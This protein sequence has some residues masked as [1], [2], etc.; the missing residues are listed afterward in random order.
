MSVQNEAEIELILA[1]QKGEEQAISELYREYVDAVYKF[2]YY[3]TGNKEEAE[4]LTT[5]TFIKM[6]KS[7][8]NFKFDSKFKTWLIG[9]AKHTVLDYFRK[10]Y[11]SKTVSIEDFLNVD[12]GD[13]DEE[14]EDPAKYDAE[15]EKVLSILPDNYRQVLELRFL[16]GYTIKE[17]A[18]ELDKSVSN[19]KVMQYRAI[20]K[21]Q[22]LTGNIL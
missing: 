2:I 19:I 16:K 13:I 17:T 12:L 22:Q 4:D 5:E 11:K 21:A 8:K 14:Q 9:I 1:A 15:V 3:R 20:K 6:M 10:H 18:E 7:L